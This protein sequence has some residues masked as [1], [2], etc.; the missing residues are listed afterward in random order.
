[1]RSVGAC[2]APRRDSQVD[3][4]RRV[5]F[6]GGRPRAPIGRRPRSAAGPRSDPIR[7]VPNR[8]D[9]RARR[10]GEAE[11]QRAPLLR[12]DVANDKPMTT[13]RASKPG[14]S[15]HR[16]SEAARGPA[17]YDAGRECIKVPS[18][19]T[20]A[21]RTDRGAHRMRLFV[22]LP[23]ASEESM[24]MLD[25]MTGRVISPLTAAALCVKPKWPDDRPV[26]RHRRPAESGVL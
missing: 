26:G 5:V 13:G 3:L 17:R 8:P 18:S 25:P 21:A 7:S 12:R 10:D 23:A 19:G 6:G 24:R 20:W 4:P 9:R 1:V 22:P 2:P 16:S 11:R 15:R 14:S